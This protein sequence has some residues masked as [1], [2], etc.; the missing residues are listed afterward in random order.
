MKVNVLKN[1]LQGLIKED[2]SLELI[3]EILKLTDNI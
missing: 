2:N 3:E 1:H